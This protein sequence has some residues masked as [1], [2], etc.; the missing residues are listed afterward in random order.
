M[1]KLIPMLLAMALLAGCGAV[2][3]PSDEPV[4][5]ARP[6]QAE[7]PYQSPGAGLS[8]E[9]ERETYDPSLTQYTYFIRNATEETVEFG[10]EYAIQRREDGV[11][12]DLT[13]RKNAGLTAIGY[14]LKP[15]A[16]QALTC[17][18]GL[19]EEI[20]QAGSY[21]L[22]KTVG[23]Q[24]LYAEFELGE[25]AYTADTPYGFKPL[26]DLPETYG[27]AQTAESDVVFTGDGVKNDGAVEEFLYKVSLGVPCQLRVVQDYGENTPMVTDTIYENG[28]FLWRMRQNG[29]ITEKRFSYIVAD[30]QGLNRYLLSNGADW[31]NTWKYGS[32]WT[33]LV[34]EEIGSW[35]AP[36]VED[37]T[38]ARLA[39]NGARFRVWSSDGVWDAALTDTPTEFSV[40]WRKPGEGSSGRTYDLQN[41]DGV[42]TAIQGLEWR[43]DGKLLLVCE[44]ADGGS[45]R[46]LFDPETGQLTTELCSLPAAAH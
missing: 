36:I 39:D 26:E 9:L 34:P 29:D 46:L 32:A 40:G 43:E 22:V 19:Y 3:L 12:K 4:A 1:K 31:E 14:A 37:M 25:S 21:R 2:T 35:L 7:T 44:T 38:A 8:M 10:E 11:W 18:L 16:A 24:T 6:E 15:G 30:G 13:L 42:E 33:A 27:A 23:G 28:H 17:S 20:P 45:S 41:W 5:P